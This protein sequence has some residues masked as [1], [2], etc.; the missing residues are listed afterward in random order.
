MGKI[1]KKMPHREAVESW[2]LGLPNK[3]EEADFIPCPLVMA[4]FCFPYGCN[5]FR[6]AGRG[7]GEWG[8]AGEVGLFANLM[9]EDFTHL[10]LNSQ[11]R[12]K[13][14]FFTLL[15]SL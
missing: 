14:S 13:G 2:P 11:S 4:D 10:A 1:H 8:G 9:E 5:L 6:I 15:A 7:G 3:E 12:L